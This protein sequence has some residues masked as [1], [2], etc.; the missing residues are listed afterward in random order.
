MA[1]E[2][3]TD[4]VKFAEVDESI[5]WMM[6]FP[7]DISAYCSTS[8]NFNGLNK[9][10][11]Y[12]GNGMAKMDPAYSY[13]GLQLEINGRSVELSQQDH[14]AAEMDD[15]AACIRENRPSKVSGEEG[16]KDLLAIEAIYKSI[17]S[18]A[19]VEVQKV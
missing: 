8:Y 14:F 6:K 13:S 5:T 4:E 2:T 3:K 18:R 11:A 7:G 15:F 9:V 17:E 19:S 16:L 1:Q 10:I 12:G